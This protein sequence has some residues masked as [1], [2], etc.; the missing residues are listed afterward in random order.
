LIDFR[1]VK[2][3]NAKTRSIVD[4][5][6]LLVINKMLNEKALLKEAL[7]PGNFS[8]EEAKSLIKKVKEE[9]VDGGMAYGMVLMSFKKAGVVMG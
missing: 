6:N 4:I 1:L 2:L 9:K 3:Q 5:Y 8:K 7:K